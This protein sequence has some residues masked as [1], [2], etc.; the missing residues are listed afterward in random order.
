MRTSHQVK[1]TSKKAS[2]KSSLEEEL[3]N[4][5]A[6]ARARHDADRAANPGLPALAQHEI[7]EIYGVSPL[8]QWELRK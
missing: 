6:D 2:P 1:R 4:A 3:N 8:L 7:D 5:A